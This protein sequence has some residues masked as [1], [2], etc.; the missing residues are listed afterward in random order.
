MA[1]ISGCRPASVRQS[2][3]DRRTTL[4][5][6]L[7]RLRGRI[8]RRLRIEPFVVKRAGCMRK[9]SGGAQLVRNSWAVK[10]S[11]GLKLRPS[12]TTRP[13]AVVQPS[14]ASG[15]PPF[16]G[17]AEN[18]SGNLVRRRERTILQIPQPSGLPSATR[19]L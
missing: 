1:W 10:G 12:V 18:V 16:I 11:G 13:T 19:C 2:I 17:N 4:C 15:A 8:E 14:R 3:A 7:R 5:L 9:R 6:T